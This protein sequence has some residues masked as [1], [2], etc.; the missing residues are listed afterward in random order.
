MPRYICAVQ[1]K[2]KNS[3]GI[4][5]SQWDAVAMRISHRG[6]RAFI[7]FHNSIMSRDLC[8]RELSKDTKKGTY[9]T[10]INFRFPK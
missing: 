3:F 8:V 1:F 10:L 6:R 5:A 7:N 4:D 2:T 9:S